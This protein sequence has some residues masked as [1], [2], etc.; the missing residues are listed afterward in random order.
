MPNTTTQPTKPATATE[1][2]YEIKNAKVF[3]AKYLPCTNSRG[4]RVKV[5]SS[6]T[7]HLRYKRK[8]VTIPW[9]YELSGKTYDK[10]FGVF[11]KKYGHFFFDRQVGEKFEVTKSYFDGG[12]YF[13]ARVAR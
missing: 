7:D 11:L 10:A 9:D 5:F 12:Y 6:M 1:T 3:V 13:T 2:V 8:S 4:V